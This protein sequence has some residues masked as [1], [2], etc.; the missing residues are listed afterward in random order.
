MPWVPMVVIRVVD[1]VRG[2]GHLVRHHVVHVAVGEV[3]LFLARIDQAVNVVFEFVVN[4]QFNPAFQV[5]F[6]IFPIP[7]VRRAARAV[8]R[9]PK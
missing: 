1:V 9:G 4:R 3:A 8:K 6:R 2:S 5:G 7:P